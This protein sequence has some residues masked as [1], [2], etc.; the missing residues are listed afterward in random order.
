MAEAALLTF[1]YDE[2]RGSQLAAALSLLNDVFDDIP[3]LLGKY[4]LQPGTSTGWQSFL[5]QLTLRLAKARDHRIALLQPNK[6]IG[7]RALN[8]LHYARPFEPVP[9]R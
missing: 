1:E 5:A 2:E 7:P 3:E 6:A 8:P 9:D 4:K